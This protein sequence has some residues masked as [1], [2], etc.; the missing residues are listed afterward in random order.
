MRDL[1]RAS[2]TGTA[3]QNILAPFRGAL[4]FVCSD[5]RGVAALHT[6][7]TLLAALRAA[8]FARRRQEINPGERAIASHPL[9]DSSD[10]QN[11]IRTD[12]PG[13]E[14]WLRQI[15]KSPASSLAAQTGWLFRIRQTLCRNLKKSR[16][17]K[18]RALTVVPVQFQTSDF[19]I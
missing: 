16:V 1:A 13:Q 8:V 10:R 14:G 15:R 9:C 18:V 6:L 5:S 3:V 7:A 11:L 4:V 12:V 17:A 2:W 19:G